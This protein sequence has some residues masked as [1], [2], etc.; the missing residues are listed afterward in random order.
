MK[1]ASLQKTKN[2]NDHFLNNPFCKTVHIGTNKPLIK[3]KTPIVKLEL[4]DVTDIVEQNIVGIEV[5]PFS[6]HESKNITNRQNFVK[7]EDNKSS[8]LS[9][10]LAP[11][12]QEITK[13][14]IIK[15]SNSDVRQ[16]NSFCKT[17]DLGINQP[18][19]KLQNP[20]VKCELE[21]VTNTDEKS[22]TNN[23]NFGTVENSNSFSPSDS[24]VPK[25]RGN[26]KISINM[27]KNV[28]VTQPIYNSVC[29]TVDLGINQP[30]KNPIIKSEPEDVNDTYEQDIIGIELVKI[31]E[32]NIGL[33]DF[34]CTNLNNIKI[35]SIEV[36]DSFKKED[37]VSNVISLNEDNYVTTKIKNEINLETEK[38]KISWE[39]FRAKREKLG[40][41]TSGNKLL[42]INLND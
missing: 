31:K 39:E 26:P 42:N 24:L 34:Y 35:E 23:Y 18:L 36:V 5:N 29:K 6:S 9:E 8:I 37:I 40:L 17:V 25:R 30:M 41:L 3:I 32:D 7:L 20:V 4:E 16:S 14:S 15:N 2:S 12:R 22:K 33:N 13:T 1:K 21:N 11:K 38:K 19:L 10:N 27:T 28:D